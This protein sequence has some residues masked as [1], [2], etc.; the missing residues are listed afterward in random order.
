MNPILLGKEVAE[1]LKD[2]VRSSFETTSP[3]YEGM[4]ER[5]LAEE[6]NLIKGPWIAVDLPF[7]PAESN[8][9]HFPEVPLG[10]RAHRHQELA[11]E[12]LRHPRAKST[13]VATGTGSGKTE[14]FLWPILDA[15]RALKGQPGIKAVI[16]YPMNALATDQARRIAKAVHRIPAL[17]GVRCGIYADAE[18]KSSTDVM[19][20][21]DVITRRAEMIANPPDILLT[22]YKMLDLLLLRGRDK[23]LWAKNAPETLRYLVVDE[24]HTFDGAQGADLALL[25]RR[26]K[27]R[28]K[29][30][31]KH[32]ACVGSSATL[33]GGEG[34]AARLTEYARDLFG[35]QFENGS[36]IREDRLKVQEY[37]GLVDYTE[38]PNPAALRSAVEKGLTQT[39][40]Q[41]ARSLACL[42]FE[43]LDPNSPYYNKALTDDPTD[44]LW[45]LEL[46]KN[47]KKHV[48]FHRVLEALQGCGKAA[49]LGDVTDAMKG[50]RVFRDWAPEAL[51]ALAEAIV[52]LTAWARDG[53]V[54]RLTPFL[55]VRVQLWAREMARMAAE[56][57]ALDENGALKPP[58]LHHSDDLEDLHLARILPVIHCRHCGTTGQIGRINAASASIG[59]D[60]ET[61]YEDF[62]EGGQH[63]RFIFFEPIKRR[64]QQNGFGGVATG[65]L[66]PRSLVCRWGQN[67][68]PALDQAGDRLTPIWIYDPVDGTRIDRTCPACGTPHSVQIL[69]L[70]SARLSATLATV[71]FNSEQHEADPN[72]KPRVLTFSDS[73]QD[74]A[75]RAAVTEIRN[76]QTVMRKAL[77]D[78]VARSADETV[79]LSQLTT[80]YIAGIREEIGEA[81]FVARFIARDQ[82]WRDTYEKL[83]LADKEPDSPRFGDDVALRLGWE[84]FS[85]LTYRARTSQTLETARIA[86]ADAEADRVVTASRVVREQ[87][88]SHMGADFALSEDEAYAFVWG[89]LTQMRRAG[90]VSHPY[91][92]LAA[93]SVSQQRPNYYA[94]QNKLGVGKVRVL[95]A[96]DA[97]RTAAPR[98]PTLRSN[99]DGFDGVARNSANNWYR[100][101][102]NRFFGRTSV[103][104]S[105]LYADLYRN[106]FETL[107]GQALVEPVGQ[108]SDTSCVSWLVRLEAVQVSTRVEHFACSHCGRRE[109]ALVGALPALDRACLRIN[110]EGILEPLEEGDARAAPSPFFAGLLQT[111][112]NHRVVAR[113]HTGILEADDRRRLENAFIHGERAWHPNFISATP[114]LE[115]GI[116][117]GDLSTLMLASVPPEEANYVQRI[118]R[119]G[120]R[121]GNSFNMTLVSARAHDLQFWEA[122]RSMLSGEVS[123]PGVH[124][125]AVAVLKRQAAAFALDR[126]VERSAGEL[127]YGKVTES[128]AAIDRGLNAEFP[129]N[130]FQDLALHGA[131]MAHA[132]LEILP[133]QARERADLCEALSAFIVGLDADSLRYR[134]QLV[135]ADAK[136]EREKL[137]ELQK[138]LDADR[139]RLKNAAPPPDDLNEQLEEIARRRAEISRTIKDSI[140]QVDVL[141]FLT[142]NGL[143][144]N[145]AFPEEGVKLKS[146]ILKAKETL[147][148]APDAEPEFVIREYVRAASQALSE[149]APLQ[150]FYA[151]GREVTIDRIDLQ[152]KDLAA[153]RFCAVC[154]HAEPEASAAQY[155]ACPKCMSPMWIDVGCRAETVELRSVVAASSEQKAAIRDLDSRTTKLYDR[156]L[157]P[158][159]S[160]EDI[161]CAYAI[162]TPTSLGPFGFEFVSQCEFRD[163]NFGPRAPGRM[164]RTVAGEQRPSRPFDI[165]RECGKLQIS[166]NLADGDHQASCAASRGRQPRTQWL[167]QVYLMRRF[168][169]EAMRIIVP[170]AGRAD[171]DDNKSFVAAIELGLKGLFAG[172]VDHIHPAVIEERLESGARVRNLYLYDGIPGGSGYLRQLASNLESMHR[173]FRHAQTALRDCA[174]RD[175]PERNGC[176]RCVKSYRTQFGPGEPRRDRALQLV[177]AVLEQWEALRPVDRAINEVLGADLLESELERRFLDKLASVFGRKSLQPIVLEQGRRGFQLTVQEQ[178]DI[179]YWQIEPQVQLDARFAGAPIRR[180]DFLITNKSLAQQKPIVVELDG[181][182]HH[183]GRI[184]ADLEARLDMMRSGRFEVWTLTWDDLENAP[185]TPNA[186]SHPFQPSAAQAALDGVLASLWSL[187]QFAHLRVYKEGVDRLR[188]SQS[189][190]A[191][192]DRLRAPLWDQRAPLCLLARVLLGPKG[193]ELDQLSPAERL[194]YDARVYLEDGEHFGAASVGDLTLFMGAPN[195]TPSQAAERA[196]QFRFFLAVEMVD[197]ISERHASARA[198]SAWRSL[199]RT[200]N[201]VQDAV[202]LQ[203][204]FPGY[205]APSGAGATARPD[206]DGV[207]EDRAWAEIYELLDEEMQSVLTALH[208]AGAIP[209]D[210]VGGDIMNGDS[211]AGMVEV[212]WS[213]ARVGVSYSVFDAPEWTVLPMP[214]PGAADFVERIGDILSALKGAM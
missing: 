101:W 29:T 11:F 211:V 153:W 107:R 105:G 89:L 55:S 115:M 203:V 9:E 187:D 42:F 195:C 183:A 82:T 192:L 36:V 73:V 28:L 200:L 62:F 213:D 8:R 152:A 65:Y 76:V 80:D 206:L 79:P 121:D 95:P 85:D 191:F 193:I 48:A 111:R 22:N 52:I 181:W 208:A 12:R 139:R 18:P 70:R 81:D 49:S 4:V 57:P 104:L 194:S 50:A 190:D 46:G 177:D 144:P 212:G 146:V 78:G 148:G 53:V 100:A 189:F 32:L 1:G 167:S 172:K 25:I 16:I 75:Q 99:F 207:A 198:K 103:Q 20:E 210:V 136:A 137:L 63:L 149:L 38:L 158:A 123:T 97:R 86:V 117:I 164:G 145:Y 174:C 56:I 173:V 3:A 161:G 163:L 133:A 214:K 180:V 61:I 102:A 155:T 58:P 205:D 45:R 21:N 90:A 106:V 93:E 124:L 14:S 84:F 83:S 185:G 91:V 112:R 118:G 26:L 69:G 41:A 5:F 196:D 186:T 150:T 10:F 201:L 119:T 66:H 108:D 159:Y 59:A 40:A 74:A 64:A 6:R 168:R 39:Q 87:L 109:M 31:E 160:N 43:D 2:L 165:C 204:A 27:A 47:L 68:Q 147:P 142:D 171:N 30:P 157:Y 151:E 170:T 34:A 184:A 131:S 116:D 179:T 94:A 7:R 54:E 178:H 175:E 132:F 15:C 141:K 128:L 71:L 138:A 176:F 199:W 72:V 125:E 98:L 96:P 197:G 162:E 202:N 154:S 77:Y 33:G 169:T 92:A 35:E 37:L 143:L 209:P 88:H 188:T 135:F 44:D 134:V 114:T 120:R 60:L 67:T 140:N 122:P 17:K 13:L 130:W 182:E 129:L 156:C 126:F 51:A 113:E 166:R 110:C 24:L 19:T 127:E 23:R